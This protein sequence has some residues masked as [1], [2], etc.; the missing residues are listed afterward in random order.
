[1]LEHVVWVSS[2]VKSICIKRQMRTHLDTQMSCMN[3][4]EQFS[5]ALRWNLGPE[6]INITVLNVPAV[7]Q[8][9]CCV[10]DDLNT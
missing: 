5:S 4:G 8:Q 10:Y 2:K 6:L 3:K 7:S 9:H 1:M